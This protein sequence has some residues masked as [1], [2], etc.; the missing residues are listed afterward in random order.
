MQ[1]DVQKLPIDDYQH[2]IED[3]IEKNPVVIITAETGAGKST[4]VPFWLWQKGKKVFVTQPRRI[5]VR[6]LSYYIS[7]ITS[8]LWGKEIGY[9]TGFDR[10]FSKETSLLYL[11][12]GVQ[13][14]KE[15]KG[16]R[17]Y[18]VLI[19]DEIHEW[20][21]SQEVL[22]GL[23]K[24]N[25]NSNFYSK[26]KKRIVIMSAT[27]QAKKLSAFLED[28]PIISV[29]GRGFPVTM[30]CNHPDF[31]LSDTVQMVEMKKNTLV[32]EPGKREIEEFMLSLEETLKH[33][34]LKAKILPLYSELSINDQQKVFKHYDIPKVVVST[35][36]AQTSL[37]IDD[38]DAVIDTGIK[39][40]V[41]I[42]KGVEGLYPV[43]ISKSECMQ[44]AG[45]AGRV[46]NGQYILCS[47]L[48][49]K[50]RIDY[51]EPEIRR[52][53]L[54]SVVLRFIKWGISPLD[55]PYFHHPK[56]SLIYKA[57]QKLK[58]FEAISSKEQITEDGKKMVEL[59]VSIRSSRF[60]IEATKGSKKVVEDSMKLISILEIKG[61]LNK[62][63]MGGKYYS[64]PYNSDLLNQLALWNS[65]NK[66]KKIISYK[67]LSMAKE[68]YKELKKR[69]RFDR[70]V[71]I[72]HLEEHKALLRAILSS[73]I[74][75]VY[76]KQGEMYTKDNEDRQLDRTSILFKT[77][78][79]MVT[80]IP[81]DLVIDWENQRTKEKE[82]KCLKLL[83]FA[84][85]LSLKLLEEL[86]PFTYKKEQEVKIENKKINVLN[87][88]YFGNKVLSI[89]TSTPEW[90]NPQE[91]E[92]V[93]RAV[94]DWY[95]KNKQNYKLEIRKSNLKTHFQE[96]EKI[97]G[98]EL[99]PF[100]FY[101]EKFIFKE[102]KQYLRSEDLDIFFNFHSGF[103]NINFSDILPYK[104]I[105]ELKKAHWPKNIQ[106]KNENL[107]IL[108]IKNRPFL[109]LTFSEFE[110][111]DKEDLVLPLG[112]RVALILNNRKF[113]QWDFAV[114][115]FNR[116]KKRKI[117]EEKWKDTKKSTFIRDLID[118]PFPQVFISGQGKENVK[119]EFYA[120]PKIDGNEI[121]LI[122]FFSKE[123]A[124]K[125]IKSIE[126]DWKSFV[127]KYKQKHIE[128][129]FKKKGWKVKN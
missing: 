52:L 72:S 3:L 86:H 43:D 40:E 104:F 36:I 118:V 53:N 10:K 76:L 65:A 109:K 12:D 67:K 17:D 64:G 62:E 100:E 69:I 103:L 56:K 129:I 68:I 119:F 46:K 93:L 82:K 6:S 50:D 99:E 89:Y 85:E 75:C 5:A 73:F 9:Q 79:D 111:I 80:G 14:I 28:A 121:Y 41:H 16:K 48:D 122:H 84:T 29:S 96:I 88:I 110:K 55:F 125:Y 102:L 24:K 126:E 120:V 27:L 32:F 101:W 92:M 38:I 116:I 31:I 113:F 94:L 20:N 58:V 128:D 39:K 106:L 83:T 47:D 98:K 30:H 127:R 57:I 105:K 44:R 26:V 1:Y 22:I 15:I 34:K 61:I 59:P 77:R 25:L 90:E 95:E 91:K 7:K 87:E 21:L 23:V 112:E 8:N 4:R 81:F 124:L 54:E 71:S 42:I 51:P 60:L 97:I 63:Y 45:R 37:T 78:P 33:D 66:N 2:I 70:F 108:Y 117:F 114:Y 19:L 18:D 107:R 123:N 35:D 115:Y 74:D 11:T 13:M 49:I